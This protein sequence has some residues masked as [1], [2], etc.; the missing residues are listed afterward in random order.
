MSEDPT[1]FQQKSERTAVELRSR[2]TPLLPIKSDDDYQAV[3][4]LFKTAQA[5]VKGITEHMAGPIEDA[6]TKHKKL[7]TLRAR[8]LK[9]FNELIGDSKR[10]IGTYSAEQQRI[11][12]ETQRKANIAAQKVLDDDKLAQ[13]E[14]A[15]NEGNSEQAD[16]ILEAP[17]AAVCVD[18]GGPAKIDGVHTRDKW[19]VEVYDLKKLFAAYGSGATTIPQ[20]DEK[21]MDKLISV[22][23]LTKLA[24]A[25]KSNFNVP[26]C[27]AVKSVVVAG[28]SS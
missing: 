15:Q 27:K 25:L 5:N 13:A 20:L 23:Q 19:D 2:V 17:T 16:A 6:H 18:V 11:A 26:G 10:A 14:Q 24:G 4:S 8:L 9:P 21:Q 1:T 3:G 22:L 28:R 12:D 7:T